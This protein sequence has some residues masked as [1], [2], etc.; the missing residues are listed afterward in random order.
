MKALEGAMW[1]HH[2]PHADPQVQKL[3]RKRFDCRD[4]NCLKKL[5]DQISA[6]R[7]MSADAVDTEQV[8]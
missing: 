8:E 7:R 2:R 6:I 4:D 1:S 3:Y 5:D